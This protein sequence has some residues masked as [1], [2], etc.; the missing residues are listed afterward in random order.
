MA[1]SSVAT[2]APAVTQGSGD[3]EG[4]LPADSS[5]QGFCAQGCRACSRG[6]WTFPGSVGPPRHHWSCLSGAPGAGGPFLALWDL[7]GIAGHVHLEF[8]GLVDLSWVCGTS[9]ASLIVSVWSSRG[10]WTFPG[11][12]GPPGHH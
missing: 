7:P 6:W 10:W 12:V 5:G 3:A 1:G 11:L 2:D 9:Q 8:Q 4:M